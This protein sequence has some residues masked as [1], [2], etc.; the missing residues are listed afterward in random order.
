MA[1]KDRQNSSGKKGSQSTSKSEREPGL[2]FTERP[3]TREELLFRGEQAAQVMESTV[4]C[5]AYQS[6]IQSYQDQILAS[7]EH[8]TRKREGLYLKMYAL[9]EAVGELGGFIHMAKNLHVD[10]LHDE[11]A[12]RREVEENRIGGLN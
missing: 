7:E 9:G 5:L 3:L 10:A 12:N 2:S 11:Q 6:T 1:E 8:E 4:F